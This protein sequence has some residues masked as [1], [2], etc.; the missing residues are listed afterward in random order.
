MK[1]DL[2]R[3]FMFR[4]FAGITGEQAEHEAA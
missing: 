2:S 3:R 1:N 4:L